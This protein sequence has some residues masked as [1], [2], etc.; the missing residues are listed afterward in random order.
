MKLDSFRIQK[1]KSIIDSGW[2]DLE[3]LTVLVG[4]NES[5]KTSL[6]KALHK[7]N[8]FHEEDYI[9]ATEWP[10]GLRKERDKNFSV[11][12]CK[13][14][15]TDDEKTELSDVLDND[16]K[17]DFVE[18]HKSYKGEFEIVDPNEHFPEKL[19]PHVV[20]EIVESLSLPETDVAPAFKEEATKIKDEAIA[21]C[22][23]GTY[24]TLEELQG[25]ISERLTPQM[26]P[27]GQPLFQNEQTWVQELSTKIQEAKKKHE[28]TMTIREEAHEMLIQW[29][30]TFIYMDDYRAFN[31]TCDL[32]EVHQR[33]SKNKATDSDKTIIML[34]ELAGLNLEDE[35]KKISEG[36][37]DT[38]QFDL[39]D[40]SK[41][42]T[43]EIENRW[44][45][46][47]YSVKFSA[48]GSAFMTYVTDEDSTELIKLEER[49]KGFQWF[50]SFD[51]AFMYESGGTFD[52]CVLLLDEPGLHLHPG[53][54]KDLLKR[55]EA[56][57]EDNTMVYTTHLPFMLN[58]REPSRIR[59]ISETETGSIVSSELSEAQPDAQ[60]VLQASLGMEGSQ[61]YLLSSH[62][63]VVEGVDDYF[64]I[65]E[66]SN[67]LNRNSR[68]GLDDEIFITP[69]GGASKVAYLS[70]MMIGQ[71]LNVFAL[72]DSD[73]SG[74]DAKDQLV[75]QWLTK[76]NETSAH[77]HLLHDL[78]RAKHPFAIEDLFPEEF[79]LDCVKHVYA[80]Q[81]AA[82]G[83]EGITL[84]KGGMLI[85]R[86]ESFMAENEIAFNKGSIAKHIRGLLAKLNEKQA[87]DANLDECINKAEALCQAI[88]KAFNFSK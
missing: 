4:K 7:F 64:F 66:L 45:S 58:L 36:D 23:K 38:R 21:I 15:L 11:C 6:L 50:F 85:K 84:K 13:F 82:N 9:F 83:V 20:D 72:L 76:Y 49:S 47:K 24:S 14:I 88:N 68:A 51:L 67:Y 8:P 29:L 75:K 48:D 28:E 10:R 60:L 39:D 87:K 78:V 42:L 65:T 77:A 5:G 27:N 30:P 59:V 26:S 18:I 53:A 86:V 57:S 79:Y 70:T 2:V 41:T 3:Q 52:N 35:V 25:A 1:Y 44:S 43:K 17:E 63:L 81:L 37:R 34:M 16:F 62:N 40:A 54:Q 71:K 69:A 22:R 80:K 32:Q 61:S 31:G 46:K 74:E 56:Y 73:G 19:H 55:L 12:S 33:N